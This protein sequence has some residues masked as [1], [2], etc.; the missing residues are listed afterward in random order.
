TSPTGR[1]GAALGGAVAN[2]GSG[3][4]TISNS[5]FTANQALGADHSNGAFA[6]NSL[7]GAIVSSATASVSDSRFTR[8]VSRAGSF[9]TGSLDASG[10]GGGIYNSGSLTL[11][12]STFSHNQPI[13]RNNSS[14]ASRPGVGV[15]GAILSGGPVTPALLV[16]SASTFDHNQAIGGNRNQS[17]SN[18]APSINGPNDAF[19]GGIHLSGGTG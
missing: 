12:S 8:N 2:L 1:V 17:S 10:A 18:P 19:G 11:T 4:L 9:C 3:S 5:A 16:V 13:R 6:G 14:S 15:G 7:G